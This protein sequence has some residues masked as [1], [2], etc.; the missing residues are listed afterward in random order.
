[1]SYYSFHFDHIKS[2]KHSGESIIENLAYSCPECNLNKGS[3]LATLNNQNELIRFFNPRID[4]WEEH[5][6]LNEGLIIAKT[7]IGEATIKI[8][9]MN[10]IERLI[11]RKQVIEL[12][13][14]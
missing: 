2:I 11:F 4:I 8:F 6:L 7:E 12:G 14:F 9:K 13:Q 3:D 1:M 10:D 5:F